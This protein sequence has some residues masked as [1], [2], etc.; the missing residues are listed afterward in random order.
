MHAQV[1]PEPP[2]HRLVAGEGIRDAIVCRLADEKRQK[3]FFNTDIFTQRLR[4]YTNPK[5]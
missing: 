2:C 5:A 4:I 1:E 3:K